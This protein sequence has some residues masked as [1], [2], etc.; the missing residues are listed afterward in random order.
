[1]RRVD[2]TMVHATFWNAQ[3]TGEATAPRGSVVGVRADA[4]GGR[5]ADWRRREFGVS[6][7]ASV[8]SE[9]HQ[10]TERQAD[11]GSPAAPIPGAE[12]SACAAVDSGPTARRA[13]DRSVDAAAGRHVDSARVRG[14]L[15]PRPCL[16]GA[17][18]PGLELPEARAPRGRARR[19]RHRSVDAERMAADKKTPLDAAPTSSSSMRAG[20]C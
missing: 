4:R 7:A 12:A 19:A 10:G 14:V 6:L 18:G 3:G 20:S 11:A 15:S 1:M 9:G 5:P 8:S 13:P 16:E 2:V 17:D